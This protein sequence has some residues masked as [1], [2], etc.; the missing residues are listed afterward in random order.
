MTLMI[1][2]TNFFRWLH[3]K[4]KYDYFDRAWDNPAYPNNHK[5]LR[6]I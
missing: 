1:P 4:S 5:N 3:I 6:S 2:I